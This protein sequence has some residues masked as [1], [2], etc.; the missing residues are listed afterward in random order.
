MLLKRFEISSNLS[1]DGMKVIQGNCCE[2]ILK[3]KWS[4]VSFVY[5]LR[6][7]FTVAT[8]QKLVQKILLMIMMMKMMINLFI[9]LVC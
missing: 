4:N 2:V 7:F 6:N 5:S 3:E 8:W 1:L 9:Y